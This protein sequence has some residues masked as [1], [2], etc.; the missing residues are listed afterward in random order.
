MKVVRT[1]L[2]LEKVI[3]RKGKLVI[4]ENI[5]FLGY[6]IYLKDFHTFT[7]NTEYLI[8]NCVFL[9]CTIKSNS[10]CRVLFNN[11]VCFK[12]CDFQ[13]DFFS[14]SNDF[15]HMAMVKYYSCNFSHYYSIK[16]YRFLLM[17]CTIKSQI[18]VSYFFSSPSR[19]NFSNIIGCKIHYIEVNIDILDR[20]SVTN[21]KI[22]HITCDN[23]GIGKDRCYR[24]LSIINQSEHLSS[25]N[26]LTFESTELE[27]YFLKEIENRT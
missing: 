10:S 24:L 7:Y 14:R 13:G 12:N 8:S 19:H 22:S 1:D 4:F 25:F 5:L 6:E 3:S 15:L 2:E 21:N 18:Y 17:N 20:V 26:N 11:N 27:K 23:V 16:S 9:D